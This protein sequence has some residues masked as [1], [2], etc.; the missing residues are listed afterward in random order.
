[1]PPAIQ[2]N[3]LS[4]QAFERILLVKPS[5]LGD[6]I[7]A[8]PVLHGLRTRYPQARIDWLV[9]NTFSSLLENHPDLTG[10]VS[11]DRQRFGRM[12][13]S[14][15]AGVE[16]VRF[17]RRLRATHYDLVVDLQGLFRTGFLTWATGAPVRIGF[18]DAREGAAWFYNRHLPARTGDEHAVDRN[19]AVASMLGFADVPIRFSLIASDAARSG[20]RRLLEDAEAGGE[21]Q[22]AGTPHAQTLSPLP[23]FRGRGQGEGVNGPMLIA[24]VP[25]ARW[26]T[27]VWPAERFTA[28]IDALYERGCRCV[29]LGGA[30]EVTLCHALAQT[31]RSSPLDLSGRSS[32]P[33]LAAVIEAVDGVLCQDSGVMHIAAALAKPLVCITGPTNPRRTG[34]YRRLEAVVRLD[35]P[36]SP[37]Y[38]RKL[39][40]CPHDHRCMRDLGTQT[41]IE[42]IQ[43]AMADNRV[44]ASGSG[45]SSRLI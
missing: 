21:G 18:A 31:C 34:P 1:M 5:S 32:L 14:P 30:D 33:V 28:V 3:D 40:Q 45:G 35:L 8:L 11:F 13:A 10:I 41:V 22:P 24:V 44:M 19:Y 12:I 2:P 7:H 23:F 38:L 36:C 15:R 6:V 17:V 9:S 39:S 37:C 4:Q 27:K 20:A 25:G 43:S 42:A 16:L 26:E 29:L